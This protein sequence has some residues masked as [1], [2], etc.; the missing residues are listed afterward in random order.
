MGIKL[1]HGVSR[2]YLLDDALLEEALETRGP[3]QPRLGQE[4]AAVRTESNE[5]LIRRIVEN[6][7]DRVVVDAQGTAVPPRSACA[8][9][10]EKVAVI[11]VRDDGWSLGASWQLAGTAVDM[12][13]DAWLAAIRITAEGARWKKVDEPHDAWKDVYP[14][15]EKEAQ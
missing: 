1:H 13:R 9:Y 4:S 5:T 14:R 7:P 11:Y 2:V 10:G 6:G 15:A 3:K 8:D 12:W